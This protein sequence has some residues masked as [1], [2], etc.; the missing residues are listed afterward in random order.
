MTHASTVLFVAAVAISAACAIV[1]AARGDRPGFTFFKPLTTCIILFGA[2]WLV[3]PGIQPYRGLVV[4]ALALSLAGDILLV[5]PANRFTA[6]L[7]AFLLAHVAYI[8]AFS[9]GN[10]PAVGQLPWLAPF[11]AFNA[12]IVAYVWNGIGKVRRPLLL[13]VVAISVMVWRAATRGHVA[14]PRPSYL[15][16]LVGACLFV[17]S[18][19]IL[20]VRRFRR[21]FRAAH[22]L[23]LSAY[24]AAQLLI[25]LSVR[26]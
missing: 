18:D 21:P 16:A 3:R 8:A 7:V 2:A 26:M 25:A 15:F 5:L 23:E 17:A 1:A 20:V 14:V 13:Y 11:L 6:G 4:L 12:A 9:T 10:P 24:W 22:E 19:A